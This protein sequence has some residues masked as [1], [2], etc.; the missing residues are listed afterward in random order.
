MRWKMKLH[1]GEYVW[2]KARD[3]EKSTEERWERMGIWEYINIVLYS[4]IEYELV[5]DLKAPMV[6]EVDEERWSI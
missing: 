1:N 2:K 5:L 4:N 3:C 6:R